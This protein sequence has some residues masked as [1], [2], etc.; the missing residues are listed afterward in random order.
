ME[1]LIEIAIHGKDIYTDEYAKFLEAEIMGDAYPSLG[2]LS[3]E[4]PSTGS[5]P[6]L[7]KMESS[8]IFDKYYVKDLDPPSQASRPIFDLGFGLSD[9]NGEEVQ[10]HMQLI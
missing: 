1:K 5:L 8:Q 2:S 9:Q 10:R 4:Y 7:E 6:S 3:L